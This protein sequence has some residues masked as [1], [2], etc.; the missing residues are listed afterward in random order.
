M[1][2]VHLLVGAARDKWLVPGGLIF[3]DRATL[4]LVGIEDGD[5]KREKIEYWDNVYGFNMSCIK[6]L[7]MQV[8]EV[9]RDL[10]CLYPYK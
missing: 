2:H 8:G 5:Y 4:T 1:C 9:L 6:S 10:T 3:P 7:A